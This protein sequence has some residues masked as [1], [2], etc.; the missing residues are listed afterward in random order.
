MLNRCT[1]RGEVMK[2]NKLLTYVE[3]TKIVRHCGIAV[4]VSKRR[5]RGAPAQ[6]STCLCPSLD[7]AER[8]GER[9]GK[10]LMEAVAVTSAGSPISAIPTQDLGQLY[11]TGTRIRW[12][13][14]ACSALTATR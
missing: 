2:G 9:H 12:E 4:A 14:A 5:S 13:F 10:K 6:T 3:R 8:R 1:R 7:R 11:V